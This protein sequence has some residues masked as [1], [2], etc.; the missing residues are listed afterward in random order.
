MKILKLAGKLFKGIGKGI[1]KPLPFSSIVTAYKE[2]KQ[3][4]WEFEK[5]VTL[6]SY[7]LVGIGLYAVISGKITIEDLIL[8][9]KSLGL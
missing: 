8:F 5:V 2:V 6:A 9:V 7:I 1:V 4:K 3:S